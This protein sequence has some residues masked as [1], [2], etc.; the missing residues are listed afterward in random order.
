[1]S[2]VVL[3]VHAGVAAQARTTKAHQLACPRHTELSR[4]AGRVAR[5][6]VGWIVEGVDAA[7]AAVRGATRAASVEGAALAGDAGVA[8][9]ARLPAGAAVRRVGGGVDTDI[10]ALHGAGAALERTEAL[11]AVAA[12]ITRGAAS[13]TVRRVRQEVH[14]TVTA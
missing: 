7:P 10:T 1:M 2:G 14:A 5:A 6:T 9:H 4:G 8:W 13:A 11:C 12:W 3:R